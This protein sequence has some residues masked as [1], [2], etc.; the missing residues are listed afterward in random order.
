MKTKFT[1]LLTAL[2]MLF[3]MSAHAEGVQGDVNGDGKV[4]KLDIAEVVKIITGDSGNANGDVTG[5]G[6]VSIADIVAIVNIMMTP[7]PPP[8]RSDAKVNITIKNTTS[9]DITIR[10]KLTFFLNYKGKCAELVVESLFGGTTKIIAAG[11]K[12]TFSNIEIPGSKDYLDCHF[13]GREEM[14]NASIPAN[15]NNVTLYDKNWNSSTIVPDM[16]NVSKT[17]TDGG[18]YTIVYSKET[19]AEPQPEP[20]PV[21]PSAGNPVININ[22]NIINNSGKVIPLGG[23]LVFVLGNPDHNGNYFGGFQGSYLRTDHIYFCPTPLTLGAGE[24]RVFRGVSWRDKDTGLGLG[25]TSP[26]TP[27]QLAAAGRPSNVMLYDMNGV[28][29]VFTVES[30]SP[31]T[32]FKDGVTYDI[33]ISSYNE[34]STSQPDVP[35]ATPTGQV[36]PEKT[37][38]INVNLTNASGRRVA[39]DGVINFVLGNPDAYGYYHGMI[40]GQPYTMPYNR[41]KCNFPSTSMAPGETKTITVTGP[42]GNRSPLK[43]SLLGIAE[44]PRN[45]LLYIGGVSEVVL[46]DNMDPGIIF[47]NGGSYNITFR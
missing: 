34:I 8:T 21:N 20:Q 36:A 33:V 22:V 5:D 9:K 38:S 19:Q 1:V 35:I 28:S 18:S 16:I 29:E 4:D 39:L 25:E 14:N 44:R 15:V 47:Q 31:S 43:P 23:D 6:K 46:C 13:A 41:E 27:S 17:F 24:K 40:N 12:K 7:T 37:I 11:G 30:M 10:P 42:L 26:A 32:V 3:S 45:V 2:L